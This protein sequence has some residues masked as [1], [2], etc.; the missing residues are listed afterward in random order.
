M[1]ETFCRPGEILSLQWQ[2]VD[3]ETRELTIRAEKA[4]TRRA[5]RLPISSRLLAVLERSSE[6]ICGRLA[7]I[8][9][10]GVFSPR[11]RLPR[12]NGPFSRASPKDVCCAG[13]VVAS[14]YA[15]GVKRYT[16]LARA[17]ARSTSPDLRASRT[18]SSL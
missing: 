14:R 4:K 10:R 3:L 5:W 11:R 13:S 1:L 12:V 6:A 15:T 7:C 17:A 18:S 2:D 9:L 8:F 16:R